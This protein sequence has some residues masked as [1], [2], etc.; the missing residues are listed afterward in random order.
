MTN[1]DAVIEK[2][3]KMASA[4]DS[5][6]RESND[7]GTVSY[8]FGFAEGLEAAIRLIKDYL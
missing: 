2:L 7:E 4:F 6:G 8:A 1:R 3:E 5:Q